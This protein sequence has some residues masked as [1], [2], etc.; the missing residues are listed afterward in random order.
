[1]VNANEWVL[2]VHGLMVAQRVSGAVLVKTAGAFTIMP[3]T[4]IFSVSK[5]QISELDL[6]S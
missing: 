4:G 5:E 1:M 3:S 6:E 2:K